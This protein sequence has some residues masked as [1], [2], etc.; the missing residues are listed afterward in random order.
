M[1]IRRFSTGDLLSR[2]SQDV[3]TVA[4]CAVSWFPN[5]IIHSFTLLATLGVVL[6][7]DPVLALIAFASTPLLF[8]ASR[9]LLRRQRRFNQ[10]M[11]QVSSGIASFQSETFRNV[12]TLKGFGAENAMVE[13]MDAWLH[14]E[15]EKLGYGGLE[16]HINEW[17][18]Y[19]QEFGT[20]HHSAEVAGMMIAM[21]RGYADVMCIYDMRANTAPYCPLFDIKTD[22]P[23]HAYYSMVAFNQLYKLGNEVECDCDTKSLYAIAASNGKKHAILLSNLTKSTQ[24]LRIDGVDLT[25]ARFYV[26]DQERLLSWSPA[27]RSVKP[28]EVFLIEW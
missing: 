23:I 15:L 1:D 6:Y 5:V 2:F 13:R 8:L 12:D 21:Q 26:I 17:N 20:A 19:P 22:K 7:Y 10:E 11:R 9:S 16:T 3:G 25:D 14:G 28:N 4:S 27:V 18:P 24:P